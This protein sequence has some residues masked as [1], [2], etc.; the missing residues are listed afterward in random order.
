MSDRTESAP[1]AT[2]RSPAAPRILPAAAT[3]AIAEA[4][5]ALADGALVGM[6]TETVYG[7]AADAANPQAVA[8][9]FAVKGRPH[10]NPLI[11]HVADRAMAG[12][13]ARIPPAAEIL[14]THFWP[15]PLTVVL[16]R[17]PDAPV[18]ELATAGLPTIALRAPA[19]ATA[20]ALIA[21]LGRPVVAPSANRS[22]HVS[23]T[24]AAHV[25]AD[26]KDAV[27]V[28]LDAGPCAVGIESTVVR[29]E[30]D[31]RWWLLRPGAITEEEIASH[32]G[33]PAR[34]QADRT[35][36]PLSPGQLLR[37]YAPG[38][39]LR[40]DATTAEV[41]EFL[42]GFGPVAGEVTLSARGDL[43]EAAARL[44]ALLR[45]AEASPKPRIAVAPIPARGLGRAIR[46]RLERAAREEKPAGSTGQ[47]KKR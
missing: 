15:G 17:R 44:F 33:P 19:H 41:D 3:R 21:T 36:R 29:V 46:D 38:K 11:A 7:L 1:S 23:P 25:A 47:G 45:E 20:Q 18:A 10:F 26:L 32:L 22:G 14:I 13:L 39:P 40:L 27:A 37:H 12:S 8:R 35:G 5:A 43:T 30:A 31:G 9:I 6:P 2:V 24:T 42:I 28:I 16:D 34:A 4:A